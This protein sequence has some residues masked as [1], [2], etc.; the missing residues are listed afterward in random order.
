MT[1]KDTIREFI[2]NELVRGKV[3]VVF[4]LSENLLE[5]NIIDSLGI[6]KLVPFLEHTFSIK[7]NDD[8]IIPD[9]FETIEAIS[10]FVQQ[11]IG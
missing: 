8:E 5:A 6:M 2:F 11:K 7:I 3:Q 4:G 9:N 10:S 1:D